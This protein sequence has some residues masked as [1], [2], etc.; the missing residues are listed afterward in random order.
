MKE[1]SITNFLEQF[2]SSVHDAIDAA[3]KR[4]NATHLVC[5]ENQQMDSSLH[6]KRSCLVIG[7]ECTRKNLDDARHH[8]GDLPSERQY[9]VNYTVIKS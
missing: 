9:P 5:Y 7:P 2:D 6:G 4:Y 8:V 3:A 1:L